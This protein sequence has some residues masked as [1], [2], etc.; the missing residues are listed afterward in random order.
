MAINGEIISTFDVRLIIDRMKSVESVRND[1]DLADRIGV[2]AGVLLKWKTRNSIPFERAV[3]FANNKRISI[4]WL[5][6]GEKMKSYQRM[7]KC[8]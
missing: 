8:F 2:E 1:K 6:F 3:E 5:V 4:D 7:N